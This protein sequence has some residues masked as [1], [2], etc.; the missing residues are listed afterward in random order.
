VAANAAFADAESFTFPLLCDT[1]RSLSVAYG[2]ADD[3]SA[4]SAKRITYVIGPDG[5]ILQAHAKVDIA[6]QPALLLASL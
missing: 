6:E 2:A 5:T 3:A 1:E 4:S